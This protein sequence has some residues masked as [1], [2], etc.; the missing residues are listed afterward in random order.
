MMRRKKFV[1]F[2][3]IS[4]TV[5]SFP[6]SS[7]AT[8]S[9]AS[10]I[11]SKAHSVTFTSFLKVF[12]CSS[13]S[14]LFRARKHCLIILCVQ[15]V[16]LQHFTCS[17][18]SLAGDSSCH[19]PCIPACLSFSASSRNIFTLALSWQKYSHIFSY[20]LFFSHHFPK[21]STMRLFL[22]KLKPLPLCQWFVTFCLQGLVVT[23]LA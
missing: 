15:S 4:W 5:L 8:F 11:L 13:Q 23:L 18:C 10:F 12:L 20:V 2:V 17:K 9:K 22:H 14:P 3:M 21:P 7:F 19:C 16:S 6:A 1:L